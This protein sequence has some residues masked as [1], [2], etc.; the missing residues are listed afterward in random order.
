MSPLRS[1]LVN[2]TA[3]SATR[4]D[5][6]TLSGLYRLL[7]AEQAALKPMW[8]LA[9]GLDEPVAESFRS[10]MEDDDSVLLMGELDD[11]SLGFLWARIEPL[12]SQAEGRRVGVVRLVFTEAEARGV[13][14]GST[15]LAAAMAE[16]SA[17][18][19]DLFDARVSPGHRNAKNFFEA[20]GFSARLIVMHHDPAR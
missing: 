13:G 15:M 7:E 11:V 4:A 1:F 8:P 12:L 5:V 19:I 16:L 14:I 17:R 10:T 18:G 2:I 20:H 9:D 3:R 6:E